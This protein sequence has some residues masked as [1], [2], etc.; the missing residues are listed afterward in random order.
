M[1]SCFLQGIGPYPFAQILRT[2]HLRRYEQ[3][4]LQYLEFLYTRHS[5]PLHFTGRFQPFSTYND[6]NGYAGYTPLGRYIRDFYVQFMESH[7][8]EIDQYTAML[9]ANI[10]QVDHSFKV[11][12]SPLLISFGFDSEYL[13][14]GT[15]TFGKGQWRTCLHCSAHSGQ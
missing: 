12:S 5:T 14:P 7:A 4:H 10:L 11:R 6:Q 9:S 3:L 1:R 2:N 8:K 15:Q 13:L